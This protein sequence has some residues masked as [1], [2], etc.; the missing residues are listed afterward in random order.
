MNITLKKFLQLGFLFLCFLSC[1]KILATS[2]IFSPLGGFYRD[3][4]V[5]DGSG[6]LEIISYSYTRNSVEGHGFNLVI[7]DILTE[8]VDN[9]TA[10]KIKFYQASLPAGKYKLLLKTTSKNIVDDLPN[11]L[12]V[13]ILSGKV[14]TII[15]DPTQP[16]DKRISINPSSF[17]GKLGPLLIE[18]QNISQN[19]AQKNLFS[20][21]S[22]LTNEFNL[23][24][25]SMQEKAKDDL[26]KKHKDLEAAINEKEKRL[27]EE[28]L[29]KELSKKN[30]IEEDN[31]S[32]VEK[33]QKLLVEQKRKRQEE[34]KEDDEMCKSYGAKIGTDAYVNCRISLNKGRKEQADRDKKEALQERLF[35]TQRQAERERAERELEIAEQ[36]RQQNA[37][38]QHKLA[39]EQRRRERAERL[40]AAQRAFDAAARLSQPIPG[41]PNTLLPQ[42]NL[43]QRT[44]CFRN[45]NYVD[46]TT[47]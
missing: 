24:V 40:D 13:W 22:S 25:K 10:G 15:Y 6:V 28:R 2:K 31:R 4:S 47:R 11:E 42:I 45:G 7:E 18:P 14:I 23:T 27:E 43:P 26:V 9:S 37:A 41:T 12:E 1:E 30:K 20:I 35:L 36:M 21:K 38:Q 3:T 46:C 16:R 29:A 39:E 34:E 8:N 5:V 17:K 44:T 32:A 19:S 33:A